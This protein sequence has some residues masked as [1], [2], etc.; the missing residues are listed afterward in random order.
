MMAGGTIRGDQIYPPGILRLKDLL[1]CFPFEDPVVLLRA[2]GQAVLEA[3]ENGVSQLP[4]L[5]GRFTQVSNISFRFKPDAPG[6]SRIT[7]VES[8]STSRRTMS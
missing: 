4:A 7:S 8:P 1:N 5:E 6:G 2:K 3:L